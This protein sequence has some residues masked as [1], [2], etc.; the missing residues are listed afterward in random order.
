MQCREWAEQNRQAIREWASENWEDFK[1]WANERQEEVL[2]WLPQTGESAG[3]WFI[4]KGEEFEDWFVEHTED[5]Y[6]AITT[7]DDKVLQYAEEMRNLALNSLSGAMPGSTPT[8]RRT[9]LR[10]E[11]LV[12]L[13]KNGIIAALCRVTDILSGG[14]VRAIMA[15]AVIGVGWLFLLGS[16]NWTIVLTFTIATAITFGAG[17]FANLISGNNYSCKM[18][19]EAKIKAENEIKNKGPCP[20]NILNEYYAGQVWN[21]CNDGNDGCTTQINNEI[22]IDHGITISLIE[23]Q[24]GYF[25]FDKTQFA[26][27]TC[28]VSGSSVGSFS[29]ANPPENESALC[30]K[31][32]SALEFELNSMYNTYNIDPKKNAKGDIEVSKGRKE[33]DFYVQ[34]TELKME[35]KKNVGLMAYDANNVQNPNGVKL[36]CDDTGHFRISGSCKKQCSLKDST[37][38]KTVIRWSNNDAQFDHVYNS[39]NKTWPEEDKTFNFG[40]QVT[41]VTCADGYAFADS[42]YPLVIECGG[43]GVWTTSNGEP[44]VRKCQMSDIINASEDGNSG[45]QFCPKTGTCESSN[46]AKTEIEREEAIIISGTCKTG[47]PGYTRVIKSSDVKL[48]YTCNSNSEWE[49][50]GGTQCLKNCALSEKFSKITGGENTV[51]WKYS[52][53]GGTPSII[54]PSTVSN[55]LPTTVDNSNSS[56]IVN[57]GSQI[58]P[59]V[60]IASH[61]IYVA[62]SSIYTCINGEFVQSGGDRNEYCKIGCKYEDL[63]NLTF[64]DISPSISSVSIESWIECDAS[65]NTAKEVKP[66]DEEV[67]GGYFTDTTICDTSQTGYVAAVLTP[68]AAKVM[69]NNLNRYAVQ[70][71]FYKISACN[72]GYEKHRDYTLIVNCT[73]S[74]TWSIHQFNWNVCRVK[75]QCYE[76]SAGQSKQVKVKSI[77]SLVNEVQFQLW[78]A[79]GGTTCAN[80]TANRGGFAGGTLPLTNNDPIYVTVGGKGGSAATS[81][82]SATNTGIVRGYAGGFNGG[83]DGGMNS[84]TATDKKGAGA[85]GGGATDI[86]YGGLALANRVAVAGGG[87]GN[88]SENTSI[89]G[90]GGGS[91]GGYSADTSLGSFGGTQSAGGSFGNSTT[92]YSDFVTKG[93]SGQGGHGTGYNGTTTWYG[94]GGGGGGYYGGGGALQS[95]AGGG[96]S[97]VNTDIMAD[98]ILNIPLTTDSPPTPTITIQDSPDGGFA[99]LCWGDW[100]FQTSPCSKQKQNVDSTDTM[101]FKSDDEIFLSNRVDCTVVPAGDIPNITN[102]T[103]ATLP[104]CSGSD[105]TKGLFKFLTDEKL[106]IPTNLTAANL[107]TTYYEGMTLRRKCKENYTPSGK[108]ADYV[109]EIT[110]TNSASEPWTIDFPCIADPCSAELPANQLPTTTFVADEHIAPKAAGTPTIPSGSELLF[111]CADDYS[112]HPNLYCEAGHWSKHSTYIQCRKHCDTSI[113]TN[114]S[115]SYADPNPSYPKASTEAKKKR[116][117]I[118]TQS[119]STDYGLSG[120]AR[121]GTC[122]NGTWNWNNTTTQCVQGCTGSPLTSTEIAN[123]NTFYHPGDATTLNYDGEFYSSVTSGTTIVPTTTN[124]STLFS[125]SGSMFD[126]DCDKTRYDE[127]STGGTCNNCGAKS[128]AWTHYY[129]CDG[130]T[131]K[132]SGNCT[133][134]SCNNASPLAGYN[135]TVGT[136][137]TPSGTNNVSFTCASGYSGGPVKFNCSLGSWSYAS[138]SCAPS[139]CSA[140][141]TTTPAIGDALL[142]DLGV[143]FPLLFHVV[144][145]Q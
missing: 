98:S 138:G 19:N 68:V 94:A 55:P 42:R 73:N 62:D 16:A 140:P 100:Y 37:Y 92:N 38:A 30:R 116:N 83:G 50:N 104:T 18:I 121:V 28:N 86:R 87:G 133:P 69:A 143:Q 127:V 76:F 107:P 144:Q 58:R 21:K 132:S 130:T 70:G 81:D 13:K 57:N 101:Y 97:Y 2:A 120:P 113:L 128:T 90:K 91:S 39:T 26:K 136:G 78:G 80:Q 8:V 145:S 47:T 114:S 66:G 72:E 1:S 10:D 43:N 129:Y 11:E 126:A 64:R 103:P 3:E 84:S 119:C 45:W 89:G 142:H 25:K 29:I 82:C 59:N 27:Y 36:I 12:M 106:A 122:T 139:P 85:G 111:D 123:G 109:P 99:R 65:G 88:S 54:N 95:A 75:P 105:A 31:G 53:N 23:C 33:D 14:F 35:C 124:I 7:I 24:S 56:I 77:N 74:G 71:T 117:S 6:E 46:T 67:C 4:R 17:Q 34:T 22:T 48:K 93:V 32:C 52:N 112:G 40:E 49:S 44:C 9:V 115:W 137:T 118:A 63:K 20:M 15:V 79:P 134:K 141:T 5:I 108:T 51:Q 131:W 125:K 96:S 61:H 135:V 41:A 102:V 110:C 60:C